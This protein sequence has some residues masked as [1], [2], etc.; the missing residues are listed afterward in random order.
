[1]YWSVILEL[2]HP[3]SE[4]RDC[5]HHQNNDLGGLLAEEIR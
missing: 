3:S 5:L 1:M 4:K 2:K